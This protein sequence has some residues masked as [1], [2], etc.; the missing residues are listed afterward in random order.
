M[1]KIKGMQNNVQK[2][3]KKGIYARNSSK[4]CLNKFKY[5]KN[6]KITPKNPIHLHFKTP[7]K[8]QDKQT[9]KKLY[10]IFANKINS[11]T[12]NP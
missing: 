9:F 5:P 4:F 11:T 7:R 8:L 1:P 10:Q 2:Y 3:T 12:K 6:C